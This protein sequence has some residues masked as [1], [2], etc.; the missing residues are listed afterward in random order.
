MVRACSCPPS[1]AAR[2]ATSSSAAAW[3]CSTCRGNHRSS[4]SASAGSIASAGASR[5]RSSTSVRRAASARM[6]CGCSRRSVSSASRSPGWSRSSPTS[7]A[8][9][10]RSRSIRWRRFPESA[11]RRWSARPRRRA[12]AS[13]KRPTSSCIATLIDRTWPP[14]SSRACPA[15]LDALN[16]EVVVTAC[17]GLGFTVERPRGHRIFAIELGNGALVD[18]L[19][20]VPGGS[21]YVGSFDREEAVENETIDFFASGHPLVEGIFA[22]YEESALGRVAR[23]EVEIGAGS[24]R[25]ARGRLQGRASVRDGCV[26]RHRPGAPGLGRGDPAAAAPRPPCRGRTS[27]DAWL[28][29]HGSPPG[30]AARPCPSPSRARRN[31]RATVAVM[32]PDHQLQPAS[33]RR[34]RRERSRE[35]QESLG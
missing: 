31:R 21:S 4:N 34:R 35:P 28:E 32:A 29:R 16:E 30:R 26:R 12:R 15:E 11:S 22:H 1:A 20:G 10:R 13:A 14:A 23:F 17:I 27:G 19:P 9:S 7:R 18:G 5:W 6:S 33:G 24:R 8:R 25:G 3:C 2:G